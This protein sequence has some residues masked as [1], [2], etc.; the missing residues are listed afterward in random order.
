[1]DKR[2]EKSQHL[3]NEKFPSKT[4]VILLIDNIN[5]YRGTRRHKRLVNIL[6]RLVERLVKNNTLTFIR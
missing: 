3:I 6:Q 5:M 2:F 4:P 1:M